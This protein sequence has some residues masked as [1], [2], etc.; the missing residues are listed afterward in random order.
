MSSPAIPAT[1]ADMRDIETTILMSIPNT[2][3]TITV[4]YS[5]HMQDNVGC[6]TLSLRKDSAFIGLG[7][8][9]V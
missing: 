6:N 4:A 5:A 2:N 3:V 8:V 7:L 1:P 9:L